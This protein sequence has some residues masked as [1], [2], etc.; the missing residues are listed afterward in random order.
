MA[1]TA[2]RAAACFLDIAARR[3]VMDGSRFDRLARLVAA[4]SRRSLLRG[5]AG[6]VSAALFGPG[7]AEAA[8]GVCRQGG[9]RCGRNAQCCSGRCSSKGRCRECKSD[10]LV[11]CP[12]EV[13]P[14]GPADS[15]C[16]CVISRDSEQTR[17]RCIAGV[18]ACLS[19]ECSDGVCPRGQV[20]VW[21]CCPNLVKRCA[22]LCGTA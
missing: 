8:T 4:G 13:I 7:G 21:T 16:L 2:D 14:C 5:L 18:D 9:V 17:P 20:C 6:G 1:T 3:W 11:V 12:L 10:W 19:G 15:G 22:P